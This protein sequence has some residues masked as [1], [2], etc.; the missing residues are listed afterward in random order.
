M[1]FRMPFSRA[2]RMSIGTTVLRWGNIRREELR[3]L[4]WC[5]LYIFCVLSAYYVIRPIRDTLGV[6]GG[7]HNLQWLF[8]ATLIA[9]LLLNLPFSALSRRLPRQRFIPISYRFFI[10]NLVIF[11]LLMFFANTAQ[12]IWIGRIFF[13]WVSV[14]N[15]FVVSV[16]W[17]L[18]VDI[19]SA[20]RGKRLFG[21]MAAGATVGAIV[22]SGLTVILAR[23]LG[24]IGLL[25]LCALLLEL[26]IVCVKRLT[27]LAPE[28]R[29]QP[30]ETKEQRQNPPPVGGTVLAGIVHTFRSP[31]LVNIC[32]YMLLFSIT[33][34]FLYFRQ[35]QLVH[36]AFASE[37]ARTT[38]FATVDLLVNVLTLSVQLFLT[39]RL[40]TRFGTA[41]VLGMLPLLSA[42]G[43]AA[44]SLLPALSS[45][46]SFTVLRRAGNFALARP[47]REVLF[48]VVSREDKYKAKSFIDTVI[49]RAGDQIGAW[50]WAGLGLAGLSGGYIVLAA[51]PLSLIW[52]VNS[53]W[54]GHRQQSLTQ[55][56]PSI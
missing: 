24:T 48:T 52:L 4:C 15:L 13:V 2:A 35:A 50:T 27:R 23:T 6:A 12:R 28:L 53:L 21:L 22:G 31:Y 45:L 36:N 34:T 38:F 5:W 55:S 7:V 47:A 43:F 32:C 9:M 10:A 3:P 44:L 8:S 54:L 42:V 46:V 26:A 37:N 41:S 33:S 19:F 20:E 14:F 25:I 18:V 39:S 16:F 17:A 56:A 30:Q 1:P 51:V 11:G 40:L 49:Y 29:D